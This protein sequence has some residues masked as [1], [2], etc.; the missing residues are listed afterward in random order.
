FE[1]AIDAADENGGGEVYIPEGT[2][3]LNPLFLKSNVNLKGENRDLV[4]L[5]LSDDANNQKM[6][7]LINV[8]GVQN[9]QI[10]QITFDGNFEK[11]QGGLEHMH[12]IFIWDS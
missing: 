11:H 2:Y 3:F 1:Q 6:T 4:T 9:I 7:R 10:K 5:K 8:E 12:A